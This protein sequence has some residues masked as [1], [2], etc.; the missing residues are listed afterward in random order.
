VT[1]KTDLEAH[2]KTTFKTAWARRSG[3]VVP[4]DGSVTLGN[5]AV[6]LEGTV[7]YADMADSTKLVDGY[8]DWFAAEV[9]KSYLYCAARIIAS[10]GGAVTAYD[11]DRVA[12]F[13]GKSKNTSAVRAALKINWAVKNIVRVAIQS[14]WPNNTFV[15]NHVCGIDTSS[16]FVAKTGVRGANDLVWVGRAANYAA[17]LSALDHNKPTWITDSVYRAV[18]DEAKFSK[19]VDMWQKHTW[20]AM[21]G[22]PVWASTYWWPL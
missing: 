5:D 7:L 4:D 1:L 20:N 3:K 22:I 6:E 10:E 18:A 14:E 2:A 21:N 19:G 17:K 16:L 8:I 9:Y 13:I 12:V 15:L 11:G